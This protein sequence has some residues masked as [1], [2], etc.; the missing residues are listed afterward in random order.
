MIDDTTNDATNIALENT[1]AQTPELVSLIDLATEADQSEAGSQLSVL[2]I[3]TE[4]VFVS[5]FT[6]QVLNVITHY[7]ERTDTWSGGYVYCLGKDCPAC[8]ALV[9]RKPF[10][11]LPVADLIDGTIKIL[12]VPTEKGPGRLLTE[13]VKVLSLPSRADI[14]TKIS[15]ISNYQ[16]VVEAHREATLHPDVA[17]AIKRFVQELETRVVNLQSVITSM[18]ASEMAQHER[19]AR[20]LELVG[21]GA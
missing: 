21:R 4:P 20:R 19:I 15:R 7:L 3:R 9:D 13:L 6:D 5:L 14:V 2:P 16:Y 17:A 10:A 1:V 12:R 8:A 11:L 18:S